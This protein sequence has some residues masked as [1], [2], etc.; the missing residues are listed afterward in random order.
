MTPKV[1]L[2]VFLV[3]GAGL[4]IYLIWGFS[5]LPDFGH[6]VGPYGDILNKIAVPERSNTDV[7]TAV[8]FDYRAIDTLGEEFILFAAVVGVASLLRTL[9]GESSRDPD[10]DAPGRR[11]PETSLAIRVA[12]LGLVA[13]T[14]LVGIYVVLHGHQAPGGGFQGGVILATALLLTYLSA[15]YMTMR[16]VGPT[17]LIE[18]AESAGAVG[19]VL[20]GLAGLVFGTAFF[21]NVLGKGTPGQLNSAGLIPFSNVAVGLAVTGGFAFMLSEFLLQT[22]VRR[23]TSGGRKRKGP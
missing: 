10:D 4:F 2:Y 11:V 23:G 14:V 22:L 1:R 12:G 16:R 17:E 6:Y 3:A 19:F 7:V 13:P 20:I 8:N 5:G 18:A 15:D 9:H 21:E